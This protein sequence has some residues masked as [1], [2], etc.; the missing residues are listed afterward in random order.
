MNG[1]CLLVEGLLDETVGRRLIRHL[2]GRVHQVYGKNGWT[3]IRDNIA[4]FNGMAQEVPLLVLVDLM[5][6]EFDCPVPVLENWVH[7]PSEHL[8][9]RLVV[10]EVESWLLADRGHIAQFLGRPKRDIP[11]SPEDLQDPKRRIINLARG[12]RYERIVRTLVP[13]DPTATEGSAYTSELRK[14]VNEHWDP[15]VAAQ[16]APSLRRCVRAVETFLNR[17]Q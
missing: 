9:F 10:P 12:S 8:F 3:W 13:D 1:F 14:F 4:G 7:S 2:G 15:D 6:T 11:R 16:N 17:Q 5:D